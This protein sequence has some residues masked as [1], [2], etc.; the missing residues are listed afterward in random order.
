M[1]A[2]TKNRNTALAAHLAG[3]RGAGKHQNRVRALR[4]G[5]SRKVKHKGKI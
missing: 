4:K 5:S 2:N 3:R 1:K